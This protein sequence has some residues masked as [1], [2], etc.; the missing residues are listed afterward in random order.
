MITR[1][2]GQRLESGDEIRCPHCRRW[3]PLIQQHTE[4]TDTAVNMLFFV[5]RGLHYFGGF[6]GAGSRHE[7]RRIEQ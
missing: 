4:G 5:C 1:M 3:H 6:I 7:T 2:D